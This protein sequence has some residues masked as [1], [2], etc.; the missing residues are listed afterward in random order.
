MFCLVPITK[1]DMVFLC[2]RTNVSVQ[3]DISLCSATC[4]NRATKRKTTV[5]REGE[6]GLEKWKKLG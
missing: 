5:F 3:T 1:L 4:H 6:H 2:L